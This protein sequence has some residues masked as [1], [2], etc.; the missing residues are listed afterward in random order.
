MVE[1]EKGTRELEMLYLSFHLFIF[2][3]CLQHAEVPELGIEPVPQ[4]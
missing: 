4:Q 2:W 3:L 1:S